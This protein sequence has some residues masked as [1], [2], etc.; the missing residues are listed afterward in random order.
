MEATDW[1]LLNRPSGAPHQA[2][3]EARSLHCS[4][5]E[6][7][8]LY[9]L[10]AHQNSAQLDS[11]PAAVPEH[12]SAKEALH[13]QI[14]GAPSVSQPASVVRTDKQARRSKGKRRCKDPK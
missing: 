12:P 10:T 14:L 3:Y 7:G 9:A 5:L 13:L 4:A 8:Y 6:S 1:L 11:M 2:P